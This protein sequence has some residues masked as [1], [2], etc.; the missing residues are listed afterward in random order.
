MAA[1]TLVVSRIV[2]SVQHMSG[3][4]ETNHRV[5]FVT[6]AEFPDGHVDDLPAVA[7]LAD[8]GVD[9]TFAVW[10]DRSVDWSAFDLVVL[11]STWDYPPRL[12]EFLEWAESI[13]NLR[14]SYEAVRWSS[15]KC[16]LAT[17]AAAGA[18]II[19]TTFV[20]PGTDAT[21]IVEAVLAMAA[22]ADD[23]V[24]KPSVGAGSMGAGRFQ[25]DDPNSVEQAIKHIGSL[26]EGDRAAMIQPYLNAIDVAGETALIYMSGEFSH[27]IRKEPML[28]GGLAEFDGLFGDERTS[29]IE[30]TTAQRATAEAVFAAIPFDQTELLYTRV[31]LLPGVNGTPLLLELEL[32]EPSLFMDGMPE[33]GERFAAAVAGA[34]AGRA[35][36]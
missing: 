26:L 15:D 3:G 18:P 29:P 21:D 35:D 23:F 34:V 25:S 22:T 2:A 33:A 32:V 11:R 7:P 24:V 1:K 16:Y 8:L 4:S 17:L 14:N 13:P 20:E 31:D 10:D 30:P 12:D 9:V 6:C 36:R 5:A 19:P 28:A 27:A